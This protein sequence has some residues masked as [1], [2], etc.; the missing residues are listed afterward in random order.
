MNMIYQIAGKIH[1]KTGLRK[2]SV[3]LFGGTIFW[4]LAAF[5]LGIILCRLILGIWEIRGVIMFCIVGYAGVIL[6]FFGGAMYLYQK[7]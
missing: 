1:E 3:F 2:N 4:M 7:K 6:G 5:L